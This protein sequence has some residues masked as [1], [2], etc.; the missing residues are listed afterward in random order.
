MKI[1]YLAISGPPEPSQGLKLD[2]MLSKLARLPSQLIDIARH[3]LNR[4]KA[5]DALLRWSRWQ[6]GSRLVPGPVLVP[7]VNSHSLLAH[8]GMTGVTQN[9][10]V[11]LAEFREMA[12]LL[13]VLRPDDLFVDV[14]A[15]IGAYTVLAGSRGCKVIA[16]E[17]IEDTFRWLRRNVDVNGLGSRVELHRCGV[18]AC[19][20]KLR[21]TTSQDTVNHVC[22]SGEA[23]EEIEVTTLDSLLAGRRPSIMK[24]DVE[25]FELQVLKG[26]SEALGSEHLQVVIIEM[27]GSCRRY[28]VAEHQ[29]GEELGRFGFAPIEYDPFRR[30]ASL[31]GEAKTAH[32]N[33]IFVRDQV[34]IT[35]R[36]A[37]APLVQLPNGPI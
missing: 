31:S 29:I 36:V 25:G 3:P 11:G 14:G 28:N 13:H 34:T 5:F 30:A 32:L 33:A 19:Q 15:N 12:F 17:P 16:I 23:G 6:I 10:Y 20:S 21:F 22:T 27:N 9:I 24:I 37:N 2:R 1:E 4:G 26:A 18:G 7:F 8:A 35:D